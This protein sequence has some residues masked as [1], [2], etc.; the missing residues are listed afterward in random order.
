MRSCSAIR[1]SSRT[2]RSA[3]TTFSASARACEEVLL[4]GHELLDALLLRH[5]PLLAHL[6]LRDHD[7]LRLGARLRGGPAPRPRAA[8][9][10]PAP[11]SAAPRAPFAPRPRPSP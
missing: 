1:R 10:A 11:P 3:T 8:R 5:P 9:C 4:R 2:F 7:L 6:S